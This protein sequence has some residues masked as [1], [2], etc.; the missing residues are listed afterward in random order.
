VSQSASHAAT[1]YREVARHGAVWTIRDASGFP[2][3]IGSNGRRAQPFWSSRTRAERIVATVPD[4]SSF[5]VVEISWNDFRDRWIPG[6]AR[7]GILIG[8]NWSGP[9]A[10]GYEVE[11]SHVLENVRGA[12]TD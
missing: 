9:R 10:T 1:F 12:S 11:P 5:S 8:V 2:A 6:L 3:P 4:Y 7:E